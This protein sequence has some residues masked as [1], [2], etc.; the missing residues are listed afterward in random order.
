MADQEAGIDLGIDGL[1][2]AEHIGRGGF[3]D[4]YR[5]EQLSLRRTVAVKVLRA[6][7]S[8]D[9]AEAKFE[10]ECHAIGA[11]SDHPHIV[12]VHE[13]GFTRNGRAYL[14]MEYLPG[15]S[16]LDRLD[17]R[18]PMDVPDI[19]ETIIKIARALSVAHRAGVLHRDVKPANIMISAYGEPALGDFG[20]ARIEGGHQTATGLVTASFAHAAPEVLEGIS[21]TAS[22]DIYSLG[23]TLFEL[24][25]GKAPYYNPADESIWPLMKRI[26]S[27]PMPTPESVG[28]SPQL[29]QVFVRATARNPSDRYSDADEVAEALEA[30]SSDPLALAR[31]PLLN[32]PTTPLE[33]HN[34]P[35]ITVPGPG[36]IASGPA[37][38]GPDSSA[39]ATKPDLMSLQHAHASSMPV[40]VEPATGRFSDR[41]G[42]R[43]QPVVGGR[44]HAAAPSGRGGRVLVLIAIAALLG[45][46]LGGVALWM[47]RSGDEEVTSA[48]SAVA[49]SLDAATQGPLQAGESYDIELESA[50]AAAQ[51][52]LVVDGE[53][54]GAVADTVTPYLPSVGRHSVAVEIT[55]D[56]GTEVTAPIE[57]YA[58]GGPPTEGYVANLGLLPADGAEAWATVLE[59]YDVLADDGHDTLAVIDTDRIDSLQP[60]NWVL[61]APGFG[62]DGDAA[63]TYCRDFELEMPDRC[64]ASY[65]R[66]QS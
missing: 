30:L 14:V 3:A 44:P 61:F 63:E 54:V 33:R 32:P 25:T 47:T 56:E 10:R 12:G 57:L 7:A 58:T 24:M 6:Q 31:Y 28:M 55:T 26:L 52:R 22:A 50:P 65:F 49:A 59:A 41:L 23:S 37:P 34:D 1:G 27:E 36:G 17:D 9:D 46:V 53:P 11:V 5:A 60:G 39:P 16:L 21:P 15:G 43:G 38:R 62:D 45:A 64:H 4:V 35:T 2:P 8:D 48:T 51:V 20:I 13:G 40:P 66:P 18:G 19:V 42:P 29:G